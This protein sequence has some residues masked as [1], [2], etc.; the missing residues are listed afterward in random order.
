M[1]N[2]HKTIILILFI[3]SALTI[4]NISC[5][6]KEKKQGFAGMAP[7][8]GVA[9]VNYSS[10]SLQREFPATLVSNKQ[11]KLVTDVGGR[12]EDILFK[13]GGHVVRGQ[14]LY[15][16]DKSLYQAAYDEA[17]A[18]LKIAQTNLVTAQT[19][20]QRYQNLWDHNAVDEI[21]LA[22]AKAQVEVAKATVD[23]AAAAVARANTNLEHATIVAP[24]TGATNVSN[25]RLGDLVVAYQTV[26]VTIVDNSQM[27]ADFYVP[28]GQ[29]VAM[30]SKND[31][32][33]TAL[34]KFNLILPD[35]SLYPLE[36]KLD[37]V[38]NTVDPTTGTILVRLIFPNP[39][40]IL[41]SGMSCVVRSEE[42]NQQEKHLIIPLQAV[43]QVLNEYYVYVVNDSGIVVD[44]KI[45]L[46]ASSNGFQIVTSG[47]KEGEKV[48]VE[49]IEKVRPNQHVKPVP[50]SEAATDSTQQSTKT[51]KD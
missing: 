16:I 34:P 30:L 23:A 18:Q 46:G 36:G 1:K 33:G 47:L 31:H 5:G 21:Q 50:Y 45:T 27:R 48:I 2:I 3:A 41:K 7:T 42:N 32:N 38:D 44:K 39:D 19:D 12:V 10:L 28:E 43:Q 49:G 4:V 40:N 29:Y 20:A 9:P 8:V 15:N 24:F 35:G 26:L 14:P 6:G 13:E 37:F 25:V 11:I 51:Q 22:H 17:V